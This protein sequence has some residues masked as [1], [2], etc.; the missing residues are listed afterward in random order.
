MMMKRLLITGAAGALGGHCRQHVS[1]LAEIVR[2]SDRDTL[3]KAAAHE[4]VVQADLADRQAVMDLVAGCDGV[5]HFRGQ[6]TEGP[7]QTVRDSNIE[8]L[9]N[10]YEPA[11]KHGCRRIFCPSS[12]HAVGYHPPIENLD[13]TIAIRPDTLY[14]VSKAFGETLARFYHEKFGI[15]SAWV[16]IASCQP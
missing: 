10:L 11:R 4:E 8:G 13:D 6:A 7:W 16:R 9:Y 3:G 15:E 14:G 2:V 1:H 5:L 12:I